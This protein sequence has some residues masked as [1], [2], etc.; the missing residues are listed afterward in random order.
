MLKLHLASLRVVPL[1]FWAQGNRNGCNASAGDVM[2]MEIPNPLGW[3]SVLFPFEPRPAKTKA[4]DSSSSS[5]WLTSF[6]W[7][8]FFCWESLHSIG[9]RLVYET[10]FRFC[11]WESWKNTSRLNGW[12]LKNRPNGISE[13][14][15]LP[16]LHPFGFQKCSKMLHPPE[17]NSKRTWKWDGWKTSLS[18]WVSAHVQV[19]LLFILGSP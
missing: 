4:S 7:G 17:T 13:H 9:S 16:N 14:H 6:L 5:N 18:F 10:F 11:S 8:R 19:R 15:H 12:N 2:W 1:M 3:I